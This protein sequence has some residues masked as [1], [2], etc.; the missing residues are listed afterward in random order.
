MRKVGPIVRFGPMPS[1]YRFDARS[2]SSRAASGLAADQSL[3]LIVPSEA[4]ARALTAPDFWV[5]PRK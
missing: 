1:F 4:V 2:L 5:R 3:S